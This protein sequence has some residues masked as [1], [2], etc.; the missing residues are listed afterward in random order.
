VRNGGSPAESCTPTSVDTPVLKVRAS[1][2]AD[3]TTAEIVL[4]RCANGGCDEKHV[5]IQGDSYFCVS[6]R[7]QLGAALALVDEACVGPGSSV[8]WERVP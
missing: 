2:F 3:C 5:T 1:G 6:R 4:A 7:R 8:E